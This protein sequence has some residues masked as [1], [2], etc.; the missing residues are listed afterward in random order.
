MSEK[1]VIE[2][3]NVTKE[4]KLFS[5]EGQK[6]K[7]LFNKNARINKKVAVND[8]SFS[9]KKGETVAIIGKNGAGKSTL[10]KMIY[11]VCFPTAGEIIVDGRVNAMLELSAGFDTDFT[12]RENIRFRC[13]L[14]GMSEEEINEIEPKIIDFA[15]LDEY[16]DQPVHTYSSGMKSK[17]GFAISVSLKPDIII[18]DEALSVG[19]GKFKAKCLEKMKEIIENDG[20]TLLFVS[21][22]TSAAREF[23][24]RGLLMRKGKIVFDGP[25]DETV[26]LYK[27]RAEVGENEN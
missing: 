1:T 25:I 9:I 21:H 13:R 4:Y 16:I 23:C 12:G 10:L 14:Y 27:N 19:D 7:Y 3:K 26:E 18:V 22:Q 8:V 5:G 6:L 2:L 11:G 15:E 24:K 20:V 17:L